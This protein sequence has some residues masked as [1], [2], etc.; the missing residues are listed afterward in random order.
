M[1]EHEHGHCARYGVVFASFRSNFLPYSNKLP[2]RSFAIDLERISQ[3]FDW[4][5]KMGKLG[6]GKQ[7]NEGIV[8]WF[9][10]WFLTTASLQSL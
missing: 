5:L 2:V 1:C 9:L 10:G 3:E 6:R 7:I 4:Q 8:S